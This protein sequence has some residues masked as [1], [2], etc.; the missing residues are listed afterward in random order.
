MQRTVEHLY[1]WQKAKNN[2]IQKEKDALVSRMGKSPLK[3]YK[4]NNQKCPIIIM[5]PKANVSS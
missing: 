4:Q 1:L 3:E 5:K 2:K